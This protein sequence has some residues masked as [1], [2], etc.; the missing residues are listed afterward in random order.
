[1]DTC[2]NEQGA[3]LRAGSSALAFASPVPV[4]LPRGSAVN[5]CPATGFGDFRFHKKADFDIK[6]IPLSSCHGHNILGLQHALRVPIRHSIPSSPWLP[7]RLRAGPTFPYIKPKTTSQV[8]TKRTHTLTL[9]VRGILPFSRG[10]LPPPGHTPVSS[11][12]SPPLALLVS[13]ATPAPS[14]KTPPPSLSK[15]GGP[16]APHLA[17]PREQLDFPPPQ[18]C[19]GCG[20]LRLCGPG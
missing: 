8:Q 15:S 7:A 10:Q 12:T 13:T 5:P 20:G 2:N 11:L 9:R 19:P 17:G 18:P 3:S 14:P 6:Q 16:R 1:M 4:P